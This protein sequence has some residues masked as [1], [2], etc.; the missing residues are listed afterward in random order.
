MMTW[1]IVNYIPFYLAVKSEW[2]FF[3]LSE[4]RLKI[5][6]VSGTSFNCLHAFYQKRTLVQFW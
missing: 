3:K 2:S 4:S 5:H 1:P 6:H